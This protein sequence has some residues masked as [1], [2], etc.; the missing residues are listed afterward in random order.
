MVRMERLRAQIFPLRKGGKESLVWREASL[1]AHSRMPGL[2]RASVVT[3]T[4]NTSILFLN[5]VV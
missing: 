1:S 5:P 4:T 3:D 2:V